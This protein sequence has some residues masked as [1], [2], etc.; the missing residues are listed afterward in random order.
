MVY[1][2]DLDM[3]LGKKMAFRAKVQP[4]FGQAS[5]WKLSYDEEFVKQLEKDYI[6]DEVCQF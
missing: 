2:D 4:T 6:A 1:P 5:V 3:L